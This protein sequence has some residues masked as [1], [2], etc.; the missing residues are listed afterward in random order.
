MVW[1]ELALRT[2]T[3][4]MGLATPAWGDVLQILPSWRQWLIKVL[5]GKAVRVDANMRNF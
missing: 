3:P 2:A 5:A 1:A 4:T